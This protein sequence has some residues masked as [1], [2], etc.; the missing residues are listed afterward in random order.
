MKFLAIIPARKNSQ[1]I[2]FKN[3]KIL[4]KKMLV[5]Y[6]I[7][8]AKKCTLLCDILVTTD[9]QQIMDVAKQ[10]NVLVPWLRPARLSLSKTSSYAV[11]RHAVSW[12]ESKIKKIDAIILLQ[13]TSPF[14][15]KK[16]ILEA[17]SFFKSDIKKNSIVTVSLSKVEDPRRWKK[18][19]NIYKPNGSIFIITKKELYKKKSFI[20]NRTRPFIINKLKESLDIDYPEDFK[21]AKKYL[22]K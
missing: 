6:T 16:N 10:K 19:I 12:Y 17:I 1:R 3:R 4:G 7:D 14:R 18:K 5:E 8:T 22:E 20:N 15:N 21:R 13:P 9:D 2:K 11:V